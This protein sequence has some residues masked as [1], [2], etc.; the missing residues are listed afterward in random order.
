MINCRNAETV[1]G[2]KTAKFAR[3]IPYSIP[4]LSILGRPLGYIEKYLPVYF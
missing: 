3:P 4:L 1:I 2:R